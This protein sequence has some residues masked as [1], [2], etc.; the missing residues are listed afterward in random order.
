MAPFTVQS[1]FRCCAWMILL[2]SVSG[3]GQ[4]AT[5]TP[6]FGSFGGGPFDTVNLANLNVH[7]SV[8]IL[9]KSGRGLPFHY[10][11]DYESS[12]WTPTTTGS[13]PSWQP[14][15]TSNWGWNALS[16][17]LTGSVKVYN[18]TGSCFFTDQSGLRH[19]IQY[20]TTTYSGY[21]DSN[22]TF[23]TATIIT[24]DGDQSCDTPVN[25]VHAGSKLA[26]DGSGYLL[27]V[28]ELSSP[29]ILVTTRS[30]VT[31]PNPGS[32]TGAIIDA[33]GNQ[34]TTNVSGSTTTFTD[35]LGIAVLAVDVV[36]P[37]QTTYTYTAPSGAQAEF[38]FN[39]SQHSIQTNFGCSGITEY[40]AT[41]IYLLD[42]IIN[43]DSSRYTFQ[44]ESTP[45]LAGKTT[46]RLASVN[47]PT[48]GTISY[49]YQGTNNGITCADGSAVT[50]Q[51]TTPDGVWIY[52]HSEGSPWSTTVTDP[53]G[54]Q[55]ALLFQGPYETQRTVNQKTSGGQTTLATTVTC[56]NGNTTNCTTTPITLPI[57]RRTAFVQL[58]TASGLQSKTDTFY[59]N[60]GS[61]TEK[62][63]YAYGSGASG[64]LL[65]KSLVSYA[66]L[67]N[68]ILDR[69]ASVTMQ[70]GNANVIGKTT[71]AYDETAVSTN[72]GTPPQH[73][74]VTGSRG[75]LTTSSSLSSGT[76]SLT[77]KYSYYNTGTVNVATDVNGAQTTYN[78]GSGS[79]GYA[80]PDST[81]LPQSLSRSA[82]YNCI[83]GVLTSSTDANGN[84]AYVDYASDP[85]F[86]RPDST[87][88]AMGNVTSIAYTGATQVE[89]T[90]S[91]NGTSTVDLLTTV[92]SL[93]R[94]LYSQQR[95]SPGSG[96]F[97]SV[98]QIYDAVDQLTKTTVPYVGTAGQPYPS[99]TPVTTTTYDA[100]GRPK[101][102]TDGGTG[103]VTL[104]YTTNDILQ[105]LGP[106]PAGE[107]LKSKQL[108]YDA[109]GRL[110]SVC[111]ITS[112][113]GSG[114]CGQSNPATGFLTKYTYDALGNLLT[115]TQNAQPGAVGGA[116]TRTY[117]YDGLS[118]MLSESNP[119]TG[120]T[121]YYWDTAA[122]NCSFGVA[123]QLS[124]KK[125]NAGAVTCY[126]FDSL[127]RPQSVEAGYG[128]PSPVCKVFAYDSL[129]YP[130]AGTPPSGFTLG[131]PLGRV[132][133][134]R[135]GNC[136]TNTTD[137]WFRYDANG[138]VTDLYESTTNSGG[139]Y[140]L[141]KSY[142][143][144]DALKSLSGIPGVPTIFY[145]NSTGSGLDGEGRVTQVT[146]GSNDE[147][148]TS[149]SYNS[150]SQV[151]GVTFGSGDS[152]TYLYDPNTGRMTQYTFAVNG[153][154]V[155]G[156]P[157]W[158]ANGT[159]QKF[160]VTQDP[161]NSANV[162]TCNY[163]YDDLARISSGNCGSAWGQTFSYDSFGNI[164]KSGS[165]SWMPN[166]SNPS[167][168]QYQPG[169]NGISYDANGNLKTDTFHTYQWDQFGHMVGNDGSTFTYEASGHIAEASWGDQYLY[170]TN[171]MLLAGSHSQAAAFFAHVRLPGGAIAGYGNGSLSE[172]KHGDWLGSVRFSSSPARALNYDLAFGPF[173]EPYA[174]S[175]VGNLFAGMEQLVAG[176]EYETLFREYNTSQ[177]RWIS[178]DPA[179]LAAADPSNPQSWNMYAYV[180]NNPLA[181]IDPFGL[182]HTVVNNPP[183]PIG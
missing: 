86:W 126:Y 100:L 27:T 177:G 20:P 75:N 174:S 82:T 74:S 83:G 64:A 150:M 88:D 104:S 112:A 18:T 160:Q 81:T 11:M 33:N 3:F 136:T 157:T 37:S 66:S 5:G 71:Y 85:S 180:A 68:N 103:T 107:N 147:L 91:I 17:A 163:G 139:Y 124:E 145:G 179:G 23:H 168:N 32:A 144:N 96:N 169:W 6:P 21:T 7:F 31:I 43:P 39:Y 25:P 62:D 95:Q 127:N 130:T 115:V 132:I 4:V 79:C 60:L 35:T 176:D 30:G 90:L 99:G 45:G 24:T 44:Y 159:L 36:S 114:S 12:F 118:R 59:N 2:L 158:N 28:N 84:T 156:K 125:D 113:S 143:A 167:N 97:D 89:S 128:Q 146:D 162:Q 155:I 183:Q 47:L 50:L 148:V 166:Y 55:S 98:Q 94:L 16:E 110:T 46:G 129:S 123:G 9:S 92:D 119:E 61:V 65:R 57:T 101:V 76:V 178:P 109:L 137:E 19:K 58:P 80:F 134:A 102:I 73:V 87:K 38:S 152:D 122:P 172:Y 34:L 120:T 53:Q 116:Q 22:G 69:P 121:Q 106:A 42:S 140:H 8:P 48:G 111:E 173:G 108:E 105:T 171:G 149:T 161:F 142:W 54:N 51:R 182:Q 67:T 154:S 170:D 165:S 15:N 14:T 63:Q 52:V 93:G 153:Q 26:V 164:A 10:V 141:S 175:H 78:Y 29:N 181:F 133:E 151:T 77:S 41:S 138:R 49:A 40:P 56:Y 131:N 70:D 13:S 135:T 72:T 117:T 1:A